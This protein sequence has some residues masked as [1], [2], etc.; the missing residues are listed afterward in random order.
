MKFTSTSSE[1]E[2]EQKLE[3]LSHLKGFSRRLKLQQ[4]ALCFIST[5]LINNKEQTEMKKVFQSMD[6]DF[7][8]KLTKEEIVEGLKKI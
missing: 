1:V 4:A 8:G 6:T 2:D 7:D 5:H 3:A